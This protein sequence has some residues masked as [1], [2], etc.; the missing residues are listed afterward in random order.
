MKEQSKDEGVITA[1]LDRF[2]NE[3]LPQALKMKEKVNRGEVLSDGDMMFL[4]QVAANA[5]DIMTI[6]HKHP[7]VEQIAAKAMSIYKEIMAK[8]LENEKQAQ[9]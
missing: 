3:R 5:K 8:A 4:G 9:Q 1:L 7:E 6:V 2:T